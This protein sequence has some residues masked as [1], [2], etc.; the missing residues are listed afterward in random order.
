MALQALLLSRDPDVQRTLRRVMDAAN[1]ELDLSNSSEQARLALT[2]RKYDAF[3]V[4]CDDT[5]N[6]PAV[7][8]ELRQGKSNR[9]CI[10]FAVI[11]GH[12]TVQQAFEMGANF[13]LDKPISIDRATRSVRAAQ[14]LILRER[15][16]YH[17][18]LVKATGAILVDAGTEIPVSITNISQGGISIECSRQLDQGGAARL[19]FQLPGTRRSL[20]IKGEVMWS[21]PEGRSGI[22]FQILSVDVKKE[23][24]AWLDRR[25]LPLGNGAMFINATI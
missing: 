3:M 11:N 25:A 12:T 21:T 13:V 14:G 8:R 2:R 15:R 16:R 22:R 4:D 18:H 23:L 19:K 9:S 5:I 24:D 20:E 7:L 17:R 1:I 10:A 6:G